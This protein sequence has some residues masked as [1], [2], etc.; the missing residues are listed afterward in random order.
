MKS[1]KAVLHEHPT[2]TIRQGIRGISGIR[3]SPS[4]SCRGALSAMF[5]FF[6]EIYLTGFTLGFRSGGGSWTPRI[7][8]GKGV[9]GVTLIEW[10]ILIGIVG[11]IEMYFGTRF[12]LSAGKWAVGITF[13]ALYYA[14]YHILI[15]RG[16]GITFEREF[17]HL[18]KSRKVLLMAAFAM[19]L[20]ATI[21]FMACSVSAYHRFFHIIPKSGW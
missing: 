11:W 15:T 17:P 21:A 13:L 9:V 10:A 14:N 1:V 5:R 6:K 7:N 16:H 2:R 18:K 8:A 20:L 12:L 19:L 4:H 3:A